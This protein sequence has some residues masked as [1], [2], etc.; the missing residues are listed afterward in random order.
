MTIKTKIKL[1]DYLPHLIAAIT[2]AIGVWQF[3]SAQTVKNKL[4]IERNQLEFER[5]YWLRRLTAYEELSSSVAEIIIYSDSSMDSIPFFKAVNNFHK[6]YWGKLALFDHND[7]S[8]NANSLHISLE[9]NLKRIA[10]NNLDKIKRKA[11]RLVKSCRISLRNDFNKLN[12][13]KVTNE[14]TQPNN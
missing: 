3:N 7:V 4:E 10:P 1:I 8:T 9:D 11:I 6:I 12:K 13:E 5:E 2:I 14:K